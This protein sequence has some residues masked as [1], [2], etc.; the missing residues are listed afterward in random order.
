MTALN[1]IADTFYKD[2]ESSILHCIKTLKQSIESTLDKRSNFAEK[3]NSY[4]SFRI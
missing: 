3:L 1:N 4:V 2:F